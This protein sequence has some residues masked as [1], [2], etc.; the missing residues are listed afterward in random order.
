[1]WLPSRRRISLLNCLFLFYYA[2]VIKSACM[3]GLIYCF[4]R[5][6]F[7]ILK[8]KIWIRSWWLLF[9]RKGLPTEILVKKAIFN[10]NLE[11]FIL[12]VIL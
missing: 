2:H 9:Y 5:Y 10:S 1:M 3:N 8:S 6:N 7:N 11:I 12:N 4:S